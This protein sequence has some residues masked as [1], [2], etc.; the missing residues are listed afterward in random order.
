MIALQLRFGNAGQLLGRQQR[1]EIPGE[2]QRFNDA[3]VVSRPLVDE[4]ALESIGETQV[5]TVAPRQLVGA[6]DRGE[7]ARLDRA[8][9]GS[10]SLTRHPRVVGTCLLLS[11]AVFHQP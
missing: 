4:L 5:L 1:Q 7:I 10:V 3:A 2:I 8:R 6:D 9:L 11:D